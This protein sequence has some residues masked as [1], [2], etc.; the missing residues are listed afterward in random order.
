LSKLRQHPY[1]QEPKGWKSR[2]NNLQLIIQP[3]IHY[4]LIKPWFT[5]FEIPD[6]KVGFSRM[7]AIM[8]EFTGW[9]PTLKQ[10]HCL[11]YS[12]A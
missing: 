2:L 12:S 3:L 8:N 4:C 10:S 11:Y 5:I 9:L 7:I 6:L 1:W